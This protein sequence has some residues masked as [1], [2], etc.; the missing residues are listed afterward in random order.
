MIKG[1]S[2]RNPVEGRS[3][4]AVAAVSVVAGIVAATAGA[5]PTGSTAIDVLFVIASVGACVWAAASAP[6][7]ALTA[8][9]AVAVALGPNIGMTLLAVVAL[10][11]AVVIG[12]KRYNWAWVRS[13]SAGISVQI[14]A[15]LD[16]RAL[17]GVTALIAIGVMAALF[18]IGA[19]RRPSKVRRRVGRLALGCAGFVVL[20]GL[21]FAA[22]A[23]SARSTVKTANDQ[24]HQALSMLSSGD[25]EGARSAFQVAE[26]S[27]GNAADSLGKPWTQGARLLPIL[28]Q[29]RSSAKDLADAATDAAASIDS[30]L[31]RLDF[32]A[33]KLTNGRLDLDAIKALEQP[34]TELTGVLDKLTTAA[35]AADNPWLVSTIKNAVV[36]LDR[37]LAK[38]KSRGD[39]ALRAVKLAPQM[40]GANGKRIYF[41]A[42]CTPAEARGSLGFMGNFAELTAD[43]G[44]LS[45]TRFGRTTADLNPGGDPNNRRITGLPEFLTDYGQYGF[46]S[47]ANGTAEDDVWQ[48][49][50]MSPDF[51]TTAQVIAQLYPQS[52]GQPVD[53]V[54]ALDPAVLASLLQITGPIPVEGSAEPLTKDNAEHFLL[55]DQYRNASTSNQD[56]IDSLETLAR[57][58]T[59]KLFSGSL[60]EPRQ[61]AKIFGPLARDK[62]LNA[63][64]SDPDEEALFQQFHADGALPALN[65]GD[66][67]GLSINNAS[68]SKIDTFLE[69]SIDYSAHQNPQTGMTVATAVITLRNTAPRAGLP[70]YV[71]GN[72]VGLDDGT[73]RALISIYSSLIA[74]S[75]TL[76]KVGLQYSALVEGGWNLEREFVD[77]APGQTRRLEIH[78]AG[79]TSSRAGAPLF[80]SPALAHPISA[81]FS[82]AET[83]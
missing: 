35:N 52:G 59:D 65:G 39:D 78:L 43:N 50:T 6:W 11:L 58:V 69:A 51:P 3:G 10:G 55:L 24:A 70:D 16:I 66:G 62:H 32:S 13:L 63:W 19:W 77:I 33:V 40:L 68:A 34:L 60:P 25:L 14:L 80:I 28:A 64:A 26:K 4:Q 82:D 41:I 22:G 36:D 56:R 76:D 83:G 38:Q 27:F 5:R 37:D 21:G 29:N 61:L 1:A 67:I 48:V 47:R 42:F 57:A 23:I 81:S 49:V 7:W 71:I 9:A 30:I 18:V 20:A 79:T 72:T 73:N 17:F 2:R 31:G 15:R 46:N 74:S 75:I 53:G 44:K 8:V 54:F 12:A 45:I